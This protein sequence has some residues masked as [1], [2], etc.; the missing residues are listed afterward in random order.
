[1]VVE[2]GFHVCCLRGHERVRGHQRV[3]GRYLVSF[4]SL[5]SFAF[6]GDPLTMAARP[7]SVWIITRR[8]LNN[9]VVQRQSRIAC[10]PRS[11]WCRGTRDE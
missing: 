3:R 7:E 2:R 1:M 9:T 10:D 8:S 11:N 4:C 6:C 5:C